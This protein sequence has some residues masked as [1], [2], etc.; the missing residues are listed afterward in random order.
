MENSYDSSLIDY[1][2]LQKEE[3]KTVFAVL[4]LKMLEGYHVSSVRD[5]DWHE[6]IDTDPTEWKTFFMELY[7]LILH[8]EVWEGES[9]YFLELDYSS[10]ERRVPRD[11]I[12]VLEPHHV[13]MA[14]MFLH[15]FYQRVLDPI[16]LIN[17]EIMRE[18]IINGEFK[19][20]YHKFFFDGKSLTSKQLAGAK[21]RFGNVC[22][23][24][25]KLGWLTKHGS[26]DSN[27]P[28]YSINPSIHRILRMYKEEFESFNSN[29]NSILSSDLLKQN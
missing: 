5:A 15:R 2:F 16:K 9:F 7:G 19:E 21:R 28:N 10:G 25:L 27:E 24:F 23:K 14:F 12:E 29:P 20:Y 4:T 22:R 26:T 17:W 1:G 6:I 11:S 8:E 18:E 3:V 13:V